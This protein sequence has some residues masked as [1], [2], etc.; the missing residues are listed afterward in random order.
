MEPPLWNWGWDIGGL[1]GS[2]LDWSG[3][4]IAASFLFLLSL[5]SANPKIRFTPTADGLRRCKGHEPSLTADLALRTPFATFLFFFPMKVLYVLEI[6]LQRLNATQY[7][8]HTN[9]IANSNKYVTC[10]E[11]VP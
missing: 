8:L 9:Y 11:P 2:E 10:R 3:A 4:L 1:R 7:L 5:V 6:D